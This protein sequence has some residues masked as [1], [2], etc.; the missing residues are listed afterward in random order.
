MKEKTVSTY[1]LWSEDHAHFAHQA[2]PSDLGGAF[3]G[4]YVHCRGLAGLIRKHGVELQQDRPTTAA[5]G[6]VLLLWWP[7]RT[8]SV[9]SGSTPIM[10]ANMQLATSLNLEM[11]PPKLLKYSSRILQPQC[12]SA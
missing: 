11:E 3:Q 5:D 10:R 6:A 1:E 9:A 8:Q 7:D 4:H 2:E 12:L